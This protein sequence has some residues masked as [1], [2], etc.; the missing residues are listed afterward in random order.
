MRALHEKTFS[1]CYKC[2]N[3]TWDIVAFENGKK[4]KDICLVK[5]KANSRIKYCNKFKG[6]KWI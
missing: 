6:L 1:L 2:K 4:W 3:W 5:N